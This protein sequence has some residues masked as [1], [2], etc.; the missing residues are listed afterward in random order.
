MQVAV[1]V[2][3][4]TGGI[5]EPVLHAHQPVER[6]KAP[7]HRVSTGIGQADEVAG[8]VIAI[9]HLAVPTVGLAHQP[10]TAVTVVARE[11]RRLRR[12]HVTVMWF[13]I[14]VIQI[15]RSA[16][17]TQDRTGFGAETWNG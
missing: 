12:H 4:E 16:E 3:A 17:E 11:R 9:A 10:A 8:R 13:R 6:V 2:V 7:R 5:V 1:G 15:S 14:W